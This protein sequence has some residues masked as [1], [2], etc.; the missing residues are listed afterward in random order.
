[1][2]FPF[3]HSQKN[4]G[5]Y[6]VFSI[7]TS[8]ITLTVFNH[9]KTGEKELLYVG[10]LGLELDSLTDAEGLLRIVSKKINMLFDSLVK[11]S[12]FSIL[13]H[14]TEIYILV[15]SPWH[16][17][18]NDEVVVQ[19]END[20]TVTDDLI[21]TV[22][23]DAFVTAHPELVIINK[24]ISSYKLNGYVVD[25]PVGRISNTLIIKAYISSVPQDFI[26]KIKNDIQKYLPHNPIKFLS[27][28]GV[29]HHLLQEVTQNEDCLILIPENEITEVVLIKN[30]AIFAEASLPFG[31]AVL[32]RAV[33][34]K[35]SSGIKESLSKMR[36]FIS[37]DLDIL[38]IED[39]GQKCN[40]EKDKFLR[41]FRDVVWKMNN[42]LVL[43]NKIFVVGRNIASHF[44]LDWI[45]KEQ[46]ASKSLTIDG[47]SVAQVR[48]N[49]IL[50]KIV[51]EKY[52]SK[53]IIP[54]TVAISL[55]VVD[56]LK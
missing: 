17:G 46:Y 16:I 36:R 50:P 56:L 35:K 43:P 52:F 6:A 12:I 8:S 24:H 27:Q 34:G 1:M 53:K 29:T 25:D 55:K 51:S 10:R 4:L 23:K 15:G 18:W 20:F 3:L 32:A 42:T 45:Q 26:S 37:G 19:K 13:K 9:K 28:T 21:N 14:T 49:D 47:F 38:N 54:F 7:D 5:S 33:F 44:V 30:R 22:V 11:S 39:I 41:C 31:S 48:G 40:E 2:L